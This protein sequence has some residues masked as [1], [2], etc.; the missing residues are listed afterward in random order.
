M[1]PS[2]MR[3]VELFEGEAVAG[4]LDSVSDVLDGAGSISDVLEGEDEAVARR[5]DSVLDVLDGAGSISDVLG[6][7]VDVCVVQLA[8]VAVTTPTT[9]MTEIVFWPISSLTYVV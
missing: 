1:A 8:V 4:R 3:L 5:L 7:A 9:P 2:L 6:G